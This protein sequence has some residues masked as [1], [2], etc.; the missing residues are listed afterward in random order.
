M[1]MIK[2]ASLRI[3]LSIGKFVTGFTD[4]MYGT[5]T[6]GKNNMA[7]NFTLIDTLAEGLQSQQVHF[8][9]FPNHLPSLLKKSQHYTLPGCTKA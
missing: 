8:Y 4:L 6:D 3:D 7:L 1:G 2:A 5:L 9:P